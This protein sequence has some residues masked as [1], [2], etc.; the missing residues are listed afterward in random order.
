MPNMKKL[1]D[2]LKI[3]LLMFEFVMRFSEKNAKTVSIFL[4]E[5]NSRQIIKDR[6]DV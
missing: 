5:K 1:S 2:Y 4:Q 6:N 3:S